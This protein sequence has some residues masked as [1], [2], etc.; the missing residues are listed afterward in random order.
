MK[1]GYKLRLIKNY[2]ATLKKWL[3]QVSEYSASM[4]Y[5][6]KNKKLLLKMILYSCFE[7]LSYACISFFVIMAFMDTSFI[8]SKQWSVGFIFFTCIV[9]YYVCAMA[10]SYIPLPGATG[11]ME[12]AFIALYGEFVGDAIVWALLTWRILSY[13]LII[14]HGFAHE[15]TKIVKNFFKSKKQKEQIN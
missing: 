3:D 13:Y 12:I 9:K 7:S 2:R 8:E 15:V 14:V 6:L 5:L 4:S 1:V 11:L 10:G